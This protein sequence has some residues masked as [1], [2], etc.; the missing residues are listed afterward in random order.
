MKRTKVAAA[1]LTLLLGLLASCDQA[2]APKEGTGAAPPPQPGPPERCEQAKLD[3]N[4]AEDGS[5]AT[6]PDVNGYEKCYFV[7]NIQ[8]DSADIR[9]VWMVLERT[10]GNAK[11][12]FDI[13]QGPRQLKDKRTVPAKAFSQIACYVRPGL[14]A[15]AGPPVHPKDKDDNGVPVA[16]VFKY[17]L[18]IDGQ[19]Q[20][21]AFDPDLRIER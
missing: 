20:T 13:C 9:E 17:T 15:S 11:Q 1:G 16:R 19:T 18:H 3:I 6:P 2:P 14:L 7:I 4:I 12:E 21:V 10:M 8:N 5:V